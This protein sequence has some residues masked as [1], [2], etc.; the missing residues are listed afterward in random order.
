MI[1]KELYTNGLY[2]FIKTA[3]TKVEIGNAMAISRKLDR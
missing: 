2:I 3:S 1:E